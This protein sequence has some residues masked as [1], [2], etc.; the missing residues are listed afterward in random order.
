MVDAAV[1]RL[2]GSAEEPC[3]PP[4][5]LRGSGAWGSN[6]APRPEPVPLKDEPVG[7]REK[8]RGFRVEQ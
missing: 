5:R 2:F 1:W 8:L 4:W 6:V 7:P 3:L